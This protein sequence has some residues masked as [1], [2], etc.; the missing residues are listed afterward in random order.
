MRAVNDPLRDGTAIGAIVERAVP[1]SL[2][3]THALFP[4]TPLP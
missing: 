4:F 2:P 3:A 1:V